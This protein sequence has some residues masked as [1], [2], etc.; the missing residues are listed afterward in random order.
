M[1]ELTPE[2]HRVNK[3]PI[4]NRLNRVFAAFLSLLLARS[5]LLIFVT[6]LFRLFVLKIR[7][8][9]LCMLYAVM[10][11]WPSRMSNQSFNTFAAI[12]YYESPVF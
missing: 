7:F 1:Q 6:R 9:N 11:L 12:A 10:T 4:I 8:H 2:V 5:C 3:L